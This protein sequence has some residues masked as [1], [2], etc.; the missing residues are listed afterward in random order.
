MRAVRGCAR[1]GAVLE[2]WEQQHAASQTHV[3]SLGGTQETRGVE[4]L[5]SSLTNY[6]SQERQ[7]CPG[8]R[9]TIARCRAVGCEC[10]VILHSVA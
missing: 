9:I 6:A 10:F 1:S 5:F 7:G 2:G 8:W 4:R 3:G